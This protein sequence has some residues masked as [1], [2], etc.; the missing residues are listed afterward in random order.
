MQ[1]KQ[2]T[3]ITTVITMADEE[4]PPSLGNS[5]ATAPPPPAAFAGS[6]SA[7]PV[8]AFSH[9]GSGDNHNTSPSRATPPS[10]D[11]NKRWKQYEEEM[12]TRRSESSLSGAK[13]NSALME[14]SYDAESESGYSNYQLP[15]EKVKR[16]SSSSASGEGLRTSG[17]SF[18]KSTSYDTNELIRKYSGVTGIPPSMGSGLPRPSSF[19]RSSSSTSAAVREEAM[20]VLDLVDEHLNA[21]FH[22]RR[23]E[24]GGFRASASSLNGGSGSSGN[25]PPAYSVSRTESGAVVV[26]HEGTADEEGAVQPYY[27]KRSSSGNITSG[28]GPR[29]TPAALS[30]LSLSDVA[31][32][33][34]RTQFKSGRYSFSDPTFRED[35]FLAEEED[36]IIGPAGTFD[37]NDPNVEV[38]ITPASTYH[39][40]PGAAFEGDF[41]RGSSTWS[42]RYSDNPHKTKRM[43]DNW[44]NGYYGN[45]E[46]QSARNMFMSTASTMKDA[47]TNVG[48]AMASGSARV[49][50]AGFSFRQSHTFGSQK[51]DMNLRTMWN[52][53]EI[54]E[55]QG[56]KVHKTWQQVMLNKKRRR[57][58]ICSLLFLVVA[59]IMIGVSVSST[60]DKR[61]AKRAARYPGSNMGLPMSFYAVSN[62]PY[63]QAQ[64]KQFAGDIATL[65]S[66][67]EFIVHVGN[68]QDAAVSL[69]PPSRFYDMASIFRR[70]PIPFFAVPGENDWVNCPNQPLSFAR[71]AH[72]MVDIDEKFNHAMQVRRSENNPELFAV[73]HNGVLFFGLHLVS[74]TFENEDAML[75]REKDM[76]N[77]VLG[78]I[79]LNKEQFRA[80]VLLGNAR[81]GPQQRSFFSSIADVLQ[82]IRAPV[83]YV[84]SD[85]GV[86][87]QGEQYTPMPEFPFIQGIQV[88]SG[89]QQKPL[90]ISVDFGGSPFVVG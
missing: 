78:M 19:R 4:E 5:N 88:P 40:D 89:G 25:I 76:K 74:G 20:Q 49:F 58:I 1:N 36:E 44:E 7:P 6:G 42:S 61:E 52:D 21:P 55:V 51:E 8:A 9:G 38:P 80:V 2:T 39:D 16:V 65:P 46:R 62:A 81:P 13:G 77:F 64:E 41:P 26:E 35:D 10:D 63:N 59:V 53:D 43:L 90:K 82:R 3:S 66:D 33:N 18:S 23:T 17:Y 29:R 79:N 56:N 68:L 83:L 12:E 87:A 31:I 69:C 71:W 67:G 86:G 70:S 27:V 84:H 37:E 45:R 28:R 50:G 11:L 57:R 30:G 24:S 14:T 73:L 22:V 32:N 75:A 60:S 85:S 72:S 54:Q 15:P 48:G 47:A 34:S